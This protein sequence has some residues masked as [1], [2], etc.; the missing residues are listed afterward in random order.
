MPHTHSLESRR[1]RYARALALG[2]VRPPSAAP[3]ASRVYSKEVKTIS[4]SLA[5]HRWHSEVVG[6][7]VHSAASAAALARPSLPSADYLA[8]RRL[9]RQRNAIVHGSKHLDGPLQ[10]DDPWL[11]TDRLSSPSCGALQSD[12][13]VLLRVRWRSAWSSSRSS[14]GLAASVAVLERRVLLLARLLVDVSTVRSSSSSSPCVDANAATSSLCSPPCV[15]VSHKGVQSSFDLCRRSFGTQYIAPRV[16]ALDAPACCDKSVEALPIVVDWGSQGGPMSVNASSLTSPSYGVD[17][18]Q[19]AISVDPVRSRPRWADL[20]DSSSGTDSVLASFSCLRPCGGDDAS[21]VAS[22][23]S[24]LDSIS[25][26]KPVASFEESQLHFDAMVASISET[27]RRLSDQTA[28]NALSIAALRSQVGL[29]MDSSVV[30]R[31]F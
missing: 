20:V 24:G 28:L 15:G 21:S 12:R 7:N 31:R 10:R 5:V 2:F 1:R 14:R 3:W 16:D 19:R 27:S 18:V 4:T 22:I 23:G 25:V 26:L 30:E 17:S 6:R 13:P 11:A 29:G 9:H 8:A